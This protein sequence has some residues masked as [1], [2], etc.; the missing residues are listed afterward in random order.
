[1]VQLMP[2]HPNTPSSLALF[3]SRLVLSFWY[4]LTQVV[5]EKW[6]LNGWSSVLEAAQSRYQIH[7]TRSASFAHVIKMV[8]IYL[9]H[10][11]DKK[12]YAS[13]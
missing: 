2:L 13:C 10:H 7:Y 1:M 11:K 5:L 9:N 6:P 3:K 4:R 12:L 8:N